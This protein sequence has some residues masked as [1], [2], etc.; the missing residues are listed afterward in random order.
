MFQVACK[1]LHYVKTKNCQNKKYLCLHTSGQVRLFFQWCSQAMWP[2]MFIHITA[3]ILSTFH[4]SFQLLILSPLN[5]LYFSCILHVKRCC[6]SFLIESRK[7]EKEKDTQSKNPK[8]RQ[9][10]LCF[11]IMSHMCFEWICT[12]Q[13]SECQATLHSKQVHYLKYKWL[14]QNSNP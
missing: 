3:Q 12:L 5:V 8:G 9:Y 6:D 2:T 7:E 10:S 11:F 1:L 14:Q 4:F 13:L